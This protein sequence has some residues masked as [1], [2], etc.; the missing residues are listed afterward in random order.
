MPQGSWQR[1]PINF[2]DLPC[3]HR[4]FTEAFQSE[5]GWTNHVCMMHPRP[6]S[7]PDKPISP[8]LQDQLL[9][10]S[11]EPEPSYPPPRF[12]T[13]RPS[14]PSVA[15]QDTSPIS[16]RYVCIYPLDWPTPYITLSY[17]E[18]MWWEWPIFT[19]RV[20]PSSASS[21]S[22]WWLDAICW[23]HPI[24]ARRFPLTSRGNVTG[25]HQLSSWT[26]GTFP[27]ATWQSGPIWQLQTY[28][29]HYRCHRRR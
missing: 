3:P 27:D 4:G 21:S 28:L 8:L 18:T 20:S 11:P 10:M 23:W 1:K 17:R 14:M 22:C 13:S 19:N 16:Q 5:A 12:T 24:Q 25:K 29:R 2:K 26:V 9:P 6:I 15:I 7:Q